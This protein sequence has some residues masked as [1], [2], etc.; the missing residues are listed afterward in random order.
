MRKHYLIVIAAICIAVGTSCG[1]PK[2]KEEPEAV[3]DEP[4]EE[5]ISGEHITQGDIFPGEKV[6]D[7]F[8]DAPI[9]ETD[10]KFAVYRTNDREMDCDYEGDYLAIQ[11]LE[12]EETIYL[13]DFFGR[14]LDMRVEDGE[15]ELWYIYRED[16]E[17][18]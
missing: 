6:Q 7:I 9:Y 1:G 12:N 11:D 4:T 10:N 15:V 5:T 18:Q 13:P 8:E 14:I 16:A 17:Q 2:I 3:P